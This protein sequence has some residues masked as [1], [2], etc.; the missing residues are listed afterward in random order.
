MYLH[1]H[2]LH[3]GAVY[4]PAMFGPAPPSF[5]HVSALGPPGTYGPAASFGASPPAP[6]TP[7]PGRVPSPMSA[8]HYPGRAGRLLAPPMPW[9]SAHD[10][11]LTP[12]A[13]GMTGRAAAPPVPTRDTSLDFMDEIMAVCY[14]S[15][16]AIILVITSEIRILYLGRDVVRCSLFYF[17]AH[18]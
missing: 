13:L 2:Q 9:T 17:F 15:L 1:Q 5:G 16:F 14:F 3:A 6:V 4:N 10:M 18:I 12:A 11:L 7:H 8:T